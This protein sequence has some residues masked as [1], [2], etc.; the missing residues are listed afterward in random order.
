MGSALKISQDHND[1]TLTLKL[2]G[3][4]SVSSDFSSIPLEGIKH[5]TVNFGEVCRID[6]LGSQG[7]VSFL[8][9]LPKTTQITF[10]ECTEPIVRQLNLIPDFNYE[11]RVNVESFYMPYFCNE[12]E[13]GV[14][15]LVER[16]TITVKNDE[17]DIPSAPCPTCKEPM[18][19]DGIL[20]KDLSF[21]LR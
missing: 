15:V 1:D 19:F 6:S 9:K 7:W 17:C 3:V 21:L 20:E 12:C 14:S 8:R 18:E 2:V 4:M 5:I 13:T 10:Q 11:K 16:D